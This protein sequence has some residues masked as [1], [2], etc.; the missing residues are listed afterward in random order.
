MNCRL[1]N[2]GLIIMANGDEYLL[3]DLVKYYKKNNS[4]E[5]N[6]YYDEKEGIL[7]IIIDSGEKYSI[8]FNEKQKDSFETNAKSI[9]LAKPCC[10]MVYVLFSYRDSLL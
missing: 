8:I 10:D 4:N 9:S 3:T 5:K 7:N 6:V 2:N 1:T